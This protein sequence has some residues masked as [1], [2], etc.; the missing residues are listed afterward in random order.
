MSRSALTVPR[1]SGWTFGCGLRCAKV[2]QTSALRPPWRTGASPPTYT[3]MPAPRHDW[4]TREWRDRYQS[5]RWRTRRRRWLQAFPLC[6]ACQALGR[7]VPATIV[8]HIDESESRGNLNDW[9]FTNRL[10]SLCFE[11]HEIKSGRRA[12]GKRPWI[13]ARTGLPCLEQPAFGERP[14][15]T[16]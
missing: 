4:H 2:G 11:H 14:T 5:E 7:A 16:R 15:A 6:C 8:D 12:G 13:D 3:P 10:Q 1:P 9:L